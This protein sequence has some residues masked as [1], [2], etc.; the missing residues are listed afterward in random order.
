MGAAA[1]GLV[2]DNGKVND[3]AA[4]G[5]VDSVVTAKVSIEVA[6]G[7]AVLA[8]LI[9]GYLLLRAITVPMGKIVSPL[10]T[11]RGGDLRQRMALHR[12]TSSWPWRKAST[13]WPTS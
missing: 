5:I 8:A 1:A 10:K 3:R 11:M 12:A 13:R 9:A 4:T 7:I 6:F 2:D